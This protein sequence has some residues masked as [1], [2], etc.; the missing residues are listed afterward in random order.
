[1]KLY[2]QH[3]YYLLYRAWIGLQVIDGRLVWENGQESELTAFLVD[4]VLEDHTGTNCV[5]LN[6][7][8]YWGLE[9]CST[10]LPSFCETAPTLTGLDSSETTASVL[11]KTTS[12]SSTLANEFNILAAN[13]NDKP[14]LDANDQCDAVR[15]SFCRIFVLHPFYNLLI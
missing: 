15:I 5:S 9:D 4:V 10:S 14:S 8:G 3:V 13:M 1:M 6:I 2:H 7:E 11:F 12:P